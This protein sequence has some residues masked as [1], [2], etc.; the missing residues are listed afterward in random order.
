MS[1]DSSP[2]QTS[3]DG[4]PSTD[5]RLIEAVGL[6]E[7]DLDKLNAFVA[8]YYKPL[9]EYMA[10]RLPVLNAEE[11]SE[12]LQGFMVEKIATLE[13]VKAADKRKGR[14]RSLLVRSLTN[15]CIRKQRRA[16]TT[17]T[18]GDSADRV[19]AK[20]VVDVFERE[21]AREVDAE[22]ERRLDAVLA[23]VHSGRVLVVWRAT[24][25]RSDAPM[26]VGELSKRYG[27]SRWT[28]HSD[29]RL[30]R[31][32]HREQLEAVLAEEVGKDKGRIDEAM[33]DWRRIMRDIGRG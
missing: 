6:D 20:R 15:Y 9:E 28:I 3:A 30:A 25:G 27:V 14:F 19:E 32:Q 12:L 31:S 4:C 24:S 26:T 5:W 17:E 16:D 8:S 1:E 18:L 11:R 13:L 33:N 23:G 2:K 7:H 29:K 21:W 10:R 22:A